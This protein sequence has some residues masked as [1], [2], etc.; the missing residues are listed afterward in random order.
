MV[1]VDLP[2]S[3]GGKLRWWREFRRLTQL[4]LGSMAEVSSKHISF[5]E[6]GRTTPSRDMILH[7]ARHLDVPLRDCNALL[8]AAGHAPQFSELAWDDD[9]FAP[10][11][12][13]LGEVVA[14]H[15]PYP[16]IVVDRYWRLLTANRAGRILREGVHPELLAPPIN[17]LRVC[18]H[19]RGLAP[20][21]VNLDEWVDHV[22]GGLARQ[23]ALSPDDTLRCLRN[24]MVDYARVAGFEPR[25]HLG[26]GRV[27]VPM[28]LRV[29]EGSVRLLVTI[30]T[31]GT[32][33]DVT[34][35]ELTIET[36]LPAD[37]QTSEI[38]RSRADPTPQVIDEPLPGGDAAKHDLPPAC[39]GTSCG[40]SCDLAST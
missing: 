3:A 1:L 8:L 22:I 13:L 21:I 17:V 36:F 12:R 27:A 24:E 7:L 34:L 32:A 25:T 14:A 31:F 10:T 2:V 40:T 15:E 35:S 39:T 9:Q 18:L 20:R 5:I 30:A 33:L 26:S 6:T 4:E 38:L 23:H 29:P 37:A 11:R 16:A 19:P 28:H